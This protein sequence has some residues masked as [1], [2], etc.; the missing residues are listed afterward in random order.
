M[1][2][3]RNSI[4]SV[5][6]VSTGEMLQM[7]GHNVLTRVLMDKLDQRNKLSLRRV[8]EQDLRSLHIELF[9]IENVYEHCLTSIIYLKF[10]MADQV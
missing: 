2:H 10:A 5:I 6:K 9:F 4:D 1:C 7:H 8:L 3:K